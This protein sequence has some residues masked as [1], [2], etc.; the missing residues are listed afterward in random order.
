MCFYDHTGWFCARRSNQWL[1]TSKLWTFFWKALALSSGRALCFLQ[2]HFLL[3]SAQ[4][5]ELVEK[6][7]LLYSQFSCPSIEHL[8]APVH[9]SGWPGEGSST[10]VLSQRSG[11]HIPEAWVS[12]GSRAVLIGLPLGR[13]SAGEREWKKTGS[14]SGLHS[15][16]KNKSHL[17]SQRVLWDLALD[18]FS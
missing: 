8:E 1:Q 11:P 6:S 14:A 2:A 18:L 15:T 9:V 5:W 16:E 12:G 7:V 17:S 4:G 13:T 3:T 10:N